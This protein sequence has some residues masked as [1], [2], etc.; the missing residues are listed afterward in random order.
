MPLFTDGNPADIEYLRNFESGILDVA[1][2]EGIDLDSKL[3][4]AASQIGDQLLMFL[5]R[6]GTPDV[7]LRRRQVGLSAVVVNPALVRWHAVHA[8]MLTFGDAYGSQLNERYAFKLAEYKA[9]VPMARENYFTVG[10]GLVNAP[11]RKA[12]APSAGSSSANA[13]VYFV[14]MS[15]A[16]AAG[17]EGAPSDPVSLSLSAGTL[18]TAPAQVDA[19]AIVWNVYIGANAGSLTRQNISPIPAGVAWA[20][21]GTLTSDGGAPGAG[22]AAEYFLVDHHAIP[23]G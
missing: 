13:A 12:A 22:Q 2:A 16:N 10:L 21:P 17:I 11:I 8:L 18:L 6:Q 1:A 5:T 23:R 7:Q 4:L 9:A 3:S 20:F 14:Q 19:P 15:W